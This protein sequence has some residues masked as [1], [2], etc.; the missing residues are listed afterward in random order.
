MRVL[1]VYECP[2]CGSPLD[3]YSRDRKDTDVLV[4][5]PLNDNEYLDE[6]RKYPELEGTDHAVILPRCCSDCRGY[7]R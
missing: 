2:H 5:N 3:Y 4:V 7:E 1:V 6:S